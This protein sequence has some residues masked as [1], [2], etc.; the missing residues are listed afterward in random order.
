L[1]PQERLKS[2]RLRLFVALDLPPELVE[3]LVAWRDTAL[4]D[5]EGLRLLPPQSLHVTLVFLGY[6]AERDVER[7]AELCF[8]EDAGPFELRAEGIV[9]VPPRRPRLYAL[10][11]EDVGGALGAWQ[12]LLSSRLERARL[13]EPEKRPFWSHVTLARGKRDRPLPRIDDPPPLPEA[14]RRPFR[15]EHATLYKSTLTPRG[16]V[17]EPLARMEPAGVSGTPPR[18]VR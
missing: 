10:G 4:A 7:I 9:G 18:R 14:L 13:Y 12:G 1:T 11:L 16:A 3:R 15:G 17:Y 8:S 5:V 2:P 6:Q